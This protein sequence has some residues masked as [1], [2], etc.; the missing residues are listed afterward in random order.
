M[1]LFIVRKPIAVASAARLVA[2]FAFYAAAIS[3]LVLR[4]GIVGVRPG[5]TALAAS[6][7]VALLAVLLALLAFVRIWRSGAAGAGRAFA[8][9]A[10]AGALLTP[11][12]YYAGKAVGAPAI[13]DVTTD[14][15]MPPAFVAAARLRPR[16]AN[17]TRYDPVL[18]A[19]QKR[20][21]PE[22]HPLLVDLPPEETRKLVLTL[23]KERK[24]QLIA[25]T[26]L[27]LPD[28]Q[29]RV[30]VRSPA[31]R[32]EAVTKSLVLG[33][34][35]DIAIRL[36]D[37][38]GRTRVDMR[39]ASRYGRFDFDANAERIDAFLEDLRTRALIPISTQSGE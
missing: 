24:W 2:V 9:F 21:Y 3:V 28:T 16:D 22:I 35:D 1:R 5:M 11:A 8:G 23:L 30:P 17:S 6:L 18:I 12:A 32:I 31:G 37:E 15:E 13:N 10:L 4:F 20:A 29:G 33:L 36:R 7:L 14:F 34:E 26:P 19:R 25:D 38:D 39:S 27:A